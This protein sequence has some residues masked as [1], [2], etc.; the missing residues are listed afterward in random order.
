MNLLTLLRK[1]VEAPGTPGFESPVRK[2]MIEELMPYVDTMIVDKLG[3]LIAS[4]KGTKDGPVIMLDAHMDEVGLMVKC[5]LPSGFILFEQNGVIDD[6]VLLAEWVNI[7][8]GEGT[9][10][11]TIGVKSRHLLTPQEAS[12][13]LSSKDMW[14]DIGVEND[15][16]AIELGVRPGDQITFDRGFK[17]LADGKSI[18]ARCL[19]DR[20]GCAIMVQ[21]IKELFNIQ[22]EA[23][24]YAVGSVQ[25]E[26]GSRGATTAAY[27][28]K[29]D[30]A[31]VYD[32]GHSI[33]PAVT[34]KWSATMMGHGPTIRLM[35][36]SQ[37]G[38][39]CI[40]PSALKELMIRAAEEETIPYQLD[41]MAGTF[42]D[43]SN[44]S[45][46]REGVPTISMCVARRNAHSM[47]ELCRFVDIENAVKLTIAFI[48]R[49]TKEFTDGFYKKLK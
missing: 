47:S 15:E 32:T 48:N 11:G 16:Q 12:L 29:P 8:T 36:I 45:L 34:L 31:L 17:V 7:H 20:V 44:I 26:V 49:V 23:T 41:L 2:I 24:V 43:S 5:V 30:L 19:D 9:L 38:K 6:R 10:T 35:D 25:E 37:T 1:L 4:K 21:S 28:I 18:L 14:I 33:D 27:Q 42:L 3:N 39:G 40:T 13:P 22:H 46:S